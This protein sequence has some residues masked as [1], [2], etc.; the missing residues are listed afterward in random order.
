MRARLL[1][2]LQQ[3]PGNINQLSKRL[4]VEYRTVMHHMEVLKK[5]SLV[6]V[7]GE[8]HYGQMYSLHPWLESHIGV[9]EGL[10]EELK[11]RLDDGASDLE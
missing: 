7:T 9:F 11:F 6:V 5:N 10:C 1:H 3:R 4:G 8:Q 2:Q